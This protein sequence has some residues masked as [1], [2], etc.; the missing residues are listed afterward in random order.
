MVTQT[1]LLLQSFVFVSWLV[2]V[3]QSSES[4]REARIESGA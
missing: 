2:V 4:Y 3:D 1:M